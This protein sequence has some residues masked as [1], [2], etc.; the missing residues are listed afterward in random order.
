MLQKVVKRFLKPKHFWRTVGFD[1][2]SELYTTMMLRGLALNL[3]GLFVPVYLYGIGYSVRQIALFYAVFF[4]SRMFFDYAAARTVAR[5][6]PKHTM[7]LSY[8]M[9]IVS[10]VLLMQLRSGR[11]SPWPAAIMWGVSSSFY[12]VAYHVDFSKIK[13]SDHGG[14]EVSFTYILDRFSAVVGPIMGG[15]VATMFGPRYTIAASAVVFGIAMIPLLLSKEPVRT[16]QKIYFKGLGK[17]LRRDALSACGLGVENSMSVVLWPLFIV[18]AVFSGSPYA[19]IGIL[20]AAGVLTAIVAA[21]MT[22]KITDNKKGKDLLDYSLM[23]N[24]VVHAFRSFVHGFAGV[25]AVNIANDAVTV[26]YRIPY[27]KGLYDAADELEG[28][29]IAYVASMECI[30]DAAKAAVWC[31]LAILAQSMQPVS[32]LRIGFFVA[33]AASML[34]MTQR[35]PALAKGA[36]A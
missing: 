19:K 9:Q 6:G 36:K 32:V 7:A 23:G 25:L 12:F 11:S 28:F 18:V 3:V 35:F 8:L 31:G 15:I 27:Y 10:L 1:E 16:H 2:L 26:G 34:I 4:G 22:G 17:I 33:V 13:H 20:S 5:F 21:R 14:K 29:R 24:M 30:G